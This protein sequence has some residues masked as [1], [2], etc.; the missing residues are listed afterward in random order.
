MLETLFKD[1]FIEHLYLRSKC[2][3][4]QTTFL[5]VFTFCD[6]SRELD[7]DSYEVVK[8]KTNT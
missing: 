5:F 2:G 8:S 6:Y 3:F 7:T 4:Q 1:S